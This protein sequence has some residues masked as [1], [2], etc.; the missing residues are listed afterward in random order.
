MEQKIIN[1]Q[2]EI[3]I[4][5]VTHTDGLTAQKARKVDSYNDL[6]PYDQIKEIQY[7]D[8]PDGKRYFN[9]SGIDTLGEILCGTRSGGEPNFVSIYIDTE[10]NLI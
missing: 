9:F 5:R 3:T 7:Y 4:L 2:E 8:T 1:F 6:I 10:D